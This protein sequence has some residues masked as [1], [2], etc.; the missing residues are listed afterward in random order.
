MTPAERLANPTS[1]LFEGKNRPQPRGCASLSCIDL[2]RA[3]EWKGRSWKSNCFVVEQMRGCRRRGQRLR[4]RQSE[5]CA[6]P[7]QPRP[8]VSLLVLSLA[9]LTCFSDFLA[10]PE[11]LP[12]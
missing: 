9:C 2:L 11:G 7:F 1:I 4:L 6:R 10:M 5:G 3:S 12:R 8:R